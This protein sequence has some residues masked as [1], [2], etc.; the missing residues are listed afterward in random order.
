MDSP[1][2]FSKKLGGIEGS[3]LPM[4]QIGTEPEGWNGVRYD[5]LLQDWIRQCL[6]R[7]TSKYSM[8]RSGIN[9]R[10]AARP[11][12]LRCAYK[13]R[14]AADQIIDDDGHLASNFTDDGIS[15]NNAGTA[16]LF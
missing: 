14:A 16:I 8:R 1:D 15:T 2:G 12:D 7:L 9:S 3:Q 6:G 11:A 10:G 13:R 4:D 5:N